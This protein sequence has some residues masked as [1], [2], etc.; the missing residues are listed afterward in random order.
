MKEEDLRR[1]DRERKP[2]NSEQLL[3]TQVK[4]YA[5]L[6]QAL[7]GS[8]VPSNELALIT[9]ALEINWKRKN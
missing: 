8:Q 1:G 9:P 6:A 5:L 4:L 7:I 3:W 2:R